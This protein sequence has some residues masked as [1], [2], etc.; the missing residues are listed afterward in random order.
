MGSS[1]WRR[2][3]ARLSDVCASAAA[4][5]P[6]NQ[7]VANER[8]RQVTGRFLRGFAEADEA[9]RA[10]WADYS[11]EEKV[12][13]LWEMVREARAIRRLEGDE[14]RL[15]RSVGRLVRR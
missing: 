13:L 11:G 12:E 3:E 8:G 14:P 10:F 6:Y 7:A 4:P 9:D 15:Q 1:W 2:R 5:M